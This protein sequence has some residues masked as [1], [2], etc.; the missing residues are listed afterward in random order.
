[1]K[2][3]RT[4]CLTA[5]ATLASAMTLA[6][7]S[8]TGGSGDSD[9]YKI[10]MLA[11]LSGPSAQAGQHQRDGAQ[12]AVDAINAAGGVNGRD[13]KLEVRDDA[14]NPNTA[15]SGFNDLIRDQSVIGMFGSTFGA[16]TLAIK[17]LLARNK[18]AV[19][20][21][22]TTHEV[23]N[24]VDEWLFRGIISAQT[25]VEAVVDLLQQA[26]L[27][28]VA[29]LHSTDAYGAQ[30]GKLLSESDLDVVA[31]EEMEA[32]ATDVTTQLTRIKAK[33]PDALLVWSITPG[34]GLVLK[35]AG[36]IGLNIPMLSGVV[37]PTAGNLTA[38]GKSSVLEHWLNV[39]LI[40]P[41]NPLPRQEDAI[42]TLKKAHS[43]YE[44]DVYSVTGYAGID[45]IAQAL[46]DAG[47]DAD[48]ESLRDSLESLQD[49]DTVAGTFSY[50]A[51]NHDGVG[52]DSVVWLAVEDGTYRRVDD[53]IS[54]LD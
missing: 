36:Q 28:K 37:G 19:L 20:A 49:V 41:A 26:G 35:N 21:P 5:V 14:G 11:A 54:V 32:D 39:G 6:G 9:T 38:A 13:L 3:N 25:E 53:P 2:L 18:I 29:I 43:D 4:L 34:A 44:P 40:D 15:V 17:P 10:G 51:D 12:A 22:N 30:G 23:T 46:E 1:M 48:R 47:D 33:Q 50:S 8:D 42:A 27:T 7:C 16:A 52:I 24:P 45:L 31:V